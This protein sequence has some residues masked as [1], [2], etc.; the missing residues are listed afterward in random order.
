MEMRSINQDGPLA[1]WGWH[2]ARVEA[3]RPQTNGVW[4][5]VWG[6]KRCNAEQELGGPRKGQPGSGGSAGRTKKN[7]GL[8]SVAVSSQGFSH[9]GRQAGAFLL[10]VVKDGAAHARFPVQ[11]DV[12]DDAVECFLAIGRGLEELADAV[13]HVG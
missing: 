1:L 3:E 4:F 9:D 8:E 6:C 10:G 12:G 13:G 7:Y 11:A 5:G 2:S